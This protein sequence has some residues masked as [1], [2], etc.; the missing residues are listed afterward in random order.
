M[1]TADDLEGLLRSTL[2]RIP[3][4]A[5]QSKRALEETAARLRAIADGADLSAERPVGQVDIDAAIARVRDALADNDTGSIRRRDARLALHKFHAFRVDELRALLAAIPALWRSWV[6]KF[7][8]M[9][10]DLD[11]ALEIACLAI[12]AQAPHDIA[13]LDDTSFG[14][15]PLFV[16]GAA[17]S[18]KTLAWSV[19]SSVPLQTAFEML[20]APSL[21]DPKWK[22]TAL[23]LAECMAN[24]ERSLLASWSALAS[25][26]SLE[27]ML[28]PSPRRDPTASWFQKATRPAVDTCIE[29]Q[30]I[31]AAALL[32][33]DG[34]GHGALNDDAKRTMYFQST[35]FRDPREFADARSRPESPGWRNVATI[36]PQDYA[37]FID[38][39]L[40]EDISL[41]FGSV[42]MDVERRD[43]WLRYVG[44]ASSSLFFLS[45]ATRQRLKAEFSG[46]NDKVKA[47]LKRARSLDD[48]DGVDAFALRFGGH[49]VVEFSRT[50]NAAY[51]YSESAFEDL[52]R[53]KRLR[54]S[55]LKDRDRGTQLRH[56]SGW[57]YRFR[58]A[59]ADVGVQQHQRAASSPQW[60]P[61]L[62][63]TPPTTVQTAAAGKLLPPPPVPPSAAPRFAQAPPVPARTGG[64]P[65]D[66]NARSVADAAD[67]ARTAGFGVIDR[68]PFGG[69]LWILGDHA[70]GKRLHELGLTGIFRPEGGKSTGGRP[71]WYVK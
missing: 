10:V 42:Q 69:A 20:T 14:R 35:A 24:P 28:L 58:S 12:L 53:G 67:I 43:F 4:W 59:L 52:V 15:R 6:R 29:A 54:V 66:R 7:F 45:P 22:Y 9:R 23:T 25:K 51:L 31:V 44:S 50:G 26:V 55:S 68:R 64:A 60:A 47:T 48:Y 46:A 11:P 19:P 5:Q 41:F 17:R 37:A 70:I 40:H 30:A 3:I 8:A 63:R 18:A 13:L 16:T 61:A 62:Q 65:V 32:R 38:S 1:T 33:R 27:A 34:S 49:V 36:A 71:A 21:L 56:A 57:E 2:Q 39:L